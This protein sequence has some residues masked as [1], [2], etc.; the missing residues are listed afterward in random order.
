MLKTP[1]TGEAKPEG[2]KRHLKLLSVSPLTLLSAF[3]QL[4]LPLICAW[5]HIVNLAS[6][7][8]SVQALMLSSTCIDADALPSP[9][10]FTALRRLRISCYDIWPNLALFSNLKELHLDSCGPVPDSAWSVPLTFPRL[11][12]LHIWEKCTCSD[13]QDP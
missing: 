10:L 2:L 4:F 9:S 5:D 8:P 12:K 7:L 6:A 3:T 1:M 11:N 13:I